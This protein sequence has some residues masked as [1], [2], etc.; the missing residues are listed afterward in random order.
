MAV[1]AALCVAAAWL[2]CATAVAQQAPAPEPILRVTLEP[3]RVVVG[4]P[5]TL[6]I[7]LL[8]PNY[9]TAPPEFPDVQVRN[10]VSRSLGNINL[11]EQKDGV[12][13]AGIRHE[14]AIHPQEAGGYAIAPDSISFT[15]AA[16]PPAGR[17]GRVTLPALAFEAFIPAAAQSLDPFIAADGLVLRQAID[18]PSGD[19]KVGDAVTR[20]ITIEVQGLPAMI[21]PPTAFPAPDGLAVYTDQPALQDRTEQRTSV[22]TG[23]R[24]D[25][26]SYILQKPGDYALPAIE[27]AWW[28]L[29][30]Q[31]VERARV[32]AVTLHVLANPSVPAGAPGGRSAAA[33]WRAWANAIVAHWPWIVL[34]LAALAG[35]AW[36]APRALAEVRQR[37]ARRQVAYLQ[38]EAWSFARLRRAARHGDAGAVYIALGRWLARF[39]PVAPAHTIAALAAA[40]QDPMLDR[41]LTLIEARLFGPGADTGAWSPASLLRRV[42]MARRRLRG[43]RAGSGRRMPP[44]AA[45]LNP[46]G[47]GAAL[48]MLRPVAR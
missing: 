39:E 26:A 10:T 37:Y 2:C 25:R 23:T 40:A 19:R 3:K 9:F 13:Y 4:Q 6:R 48:R 21:L 18:P 7:E 36:G 15:Y 45:S 32:D 46:G 33:S 24:I 35:L 31:K 22:L 34:A 14:V 30:E 17:P 28:N 43:R 29:T 8:A 20:T 38:S 5:V 27:V 44:L 47:P 16:E 11:T 12:T 41:E 1:W 42:T